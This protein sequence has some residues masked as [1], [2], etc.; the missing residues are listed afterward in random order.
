MAGVMLVTG[1]GR[2]I[3]AAIARQGAARGWRVAVACPDGGRLRLAISPRTQ[4]SFGN[5]RPSTVPIP[6]L[7]SATENVGSSANN[8]SCT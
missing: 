2:G 5:A 1:A 6:A 3:G 7:S 8:G 4:S